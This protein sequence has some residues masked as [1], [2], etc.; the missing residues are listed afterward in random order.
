MEALRQEVNMLK[1]RLDRQPKPA[2]LQDLEAVSLCVCVCVF[3]C[4]CYL[5][6]NPA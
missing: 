1:S 4:V 2:S 6:F 3:V 5:Y